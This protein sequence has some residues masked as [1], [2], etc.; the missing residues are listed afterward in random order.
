VEIADGVLSL[1]EPSA[2]VSC[3][4][5]AA[6]PLVAARDPDIKTSIDLFFGT[7]RPFPFGDLLAAV[8]LGAALVTAAVAVLDRSPVLRVGVLVGGSASVALSFVD[9]ATEH[10]S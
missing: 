3:C 8:D 1:D 5:A 7:A 10:S 2:A 9:G 6:G 4:C